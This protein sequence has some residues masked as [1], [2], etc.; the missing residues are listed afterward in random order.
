MKIVTWN[1]RCIWSGYDGIYSFV[2]RAGIIYEKILEEMPDVIAFQEVTVDS[3][4]LMKRMLPEYVFFGSFREESFDGEGLFTAFRKKKY[5]LM[6]GDVFWCS[7]TPYLPGSRFANQSEYPRICICTKLRDLKTHKTIRFI[8]VHLDN[9]SDEARKLGLDCIFNYIATHNAADK[10]PTMILGD[11]N[12][13]PESET[14]GAVFAKDWLVDATASIKETTFHDFGK[15]DNEK[16][17]YIFMTKDLSGYIVNVQ[18]WK[19]EQNGIYL[20][21]HYPICVELK[22]N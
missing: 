8:N 12:A 17:D 14:M 6:T 2:H 13:V 15:V 21:D 18:L 10:Q 22:E 19:D 5:A 1:L 7:L 9:E 20:S 16:I 4:E 3:L 11:F